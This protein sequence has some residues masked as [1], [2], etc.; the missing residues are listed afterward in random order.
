MIGG[1]RRNSYADWDSTIKLVA[2]DRKEAL[3]TQKLSKMYH[4]KNT[5]R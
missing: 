1:N 2:L 4:N 3:L 5:K